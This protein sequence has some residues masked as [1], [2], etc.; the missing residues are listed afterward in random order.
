M[1]TYKFQTPIP[2]S[3]EQVYEHVTGFTDGGPAN[4]KALAAKHGELVEREGDIDVFKGAS[5]DDPTWRCTYD[6]PRQRVMMAQESKW[7]DRLDLFEAAADDSTLWTVEWRPKASGI[8]AY[9]QLIGYHIRGKQHLY[10]SVIIPVVTHFQDRTTTRH[11][12]RS[13]RHRRPRQ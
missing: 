8:Q 12:T 5:E 2:A 13:R 10:A 11:R 6:R 4:L 3:I 9:T 7:A 1:P